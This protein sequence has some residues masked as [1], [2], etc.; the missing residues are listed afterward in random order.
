MKRNVLALALI[1]SF[2]FSAVIATQFT[3]SA[4]AQTYSA[5]TIKPDGSIKGTDKIQR[6]ENVYTLTGNTSDG[7]QIQKSHIVLDGAGYAIEGNGEGIGIDLS[8][9]CWRDQSRAQI[10]NVTVKN[11]KITNWSNAIEF[12]ASAN[13]T[14]IGNYVSDCYTGFN[15]WYTANHTLMHNTI[16]NCVTGITISFGGSGNVVAE[17]NILN[18]S[19]FVMEQ[20]PDNTVDRNYWSDYL[21]RYPN[22]T[23]IGN[24]GI[25]DTPYEGHEFF[26][27]NHPLVEPV[28]VNS[29]LPD[30][31][32]FP[33]LMVITVTIMVVAAVAVGLLVFKKRKHKV[34]TTNR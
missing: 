9:E 10:K 17:N 3:N 11:L 8:N 15:I 16:E 6:N 22:A 28:A 4:T 13:D 18:S 24:T 33:I 21:T 34:E 7:I 30:E 27:D 29:E 2:L 14:F 20:C 26:T 19:V 1:F 12:V 25:W 5:I 23:E 31:E 32:P